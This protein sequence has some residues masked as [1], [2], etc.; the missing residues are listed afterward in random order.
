MANLIGSGI[1]QISPNG[2]LGNMAFQDKTY[3][4]VDQIGVGSVFSDSGTSNQLLQVQGGAYVSSNTG[5]ANTNPTALVHIGAGTTVATTSPLKFSAGSN[6]TAIEAGTVEYDGTTLF[7]TPNANFG[8][9]VIPTTLYTTGAGTAGITSLTNYALFP[10]AN[11]T[12]TLSN[13]TYLVRTGFRVAVSGSTVSSTLTLNLRGGGSAVGTFSWRGTSAIVDSGASN[14]FAVS[15]TA[16]GTVITLTAAS[17]TDPR[18]YIVAGE[19]I[20]KITTSGT[21]VPSYQFP[22]TLT[23]GTTTLVADN[24][25]ILQSLDTQNSTAFGPAGA[26][27]N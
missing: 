6:L 4:S 22:S 9:A 27:W 15:A 17:A 14:S 26:G 1:N 20:L 19:G 5:I 11:D 12:I 24:Y 23:G 10:A 3:V 2:L 25:L 8:R 21:I 7:S 13:G 16:L 18:Q